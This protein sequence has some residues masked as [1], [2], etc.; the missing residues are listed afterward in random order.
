MGLMIV[1]FVVVAIIIFSKLSELN[2]KISSLQ[3][4]MTGLYK[5]IEKISPKTVAPPAEQLKAA[6]E[7]EIKIASPEI[8]AQKPPE[9]QVQPEK[10]KTDTS[11][12]IHEDTRKNWLKLERII[13]ERWLV[14][15]GALAFA[16]GFGVFMK[17]AFEQGWIN[18]V[19]R[20]TLGFL[21]GLIFIG[22]SEFL[23]KKNFQALAQGISALGL[24]ILYLTTFTAYHFYHMFG[25]WTA[26]IIFFATTVGGMYTAMHHNAFAT[27][28]LTTLGAFAT[29]LLLVDPASTVNYAPKLFSYL[30]IINAGVLYASSAKRWRILSLFSFLC[31]VFYFE[32]W[33][34]REYV[35]SDFLMAL[36]FAVIY[37]ITFSLISAVYSIIRKGRSKWEDIILV[38][39]N[40]VI[41]F[42]LLYDILD[43]AGRTALLPCIPLLMAAYH[44]ILAGIIRKINGRDIFL[45]FALVGTAVGLLTL[46]VPMLVKSYW[47][48]AVWGAEALIFL[49]IGS[50][51]DR[52]SLRIGGLAIFFLVVLRLFL[53]DSA[54]PY[55]RIYDSLLFFNR[56]FLALLISSLTFGLAGIS[57][58]K[59]KN[60]TPEEKEYSAPLWAVFTMALFWIANIEVFTYFSASGWTDGIE[61]I[62]TTMLWAVFSF[63]LF[64]IGAKEKIPAF[65]TAGLILITAASLKAVIDSFFTCRYTYG[66]PLLFNLKFLSV[67]TLLFTM[68]YAAALYGSERI[69][70][71]SLEKTAVPYL[72]GLF[73]I[74]LF[75]ELNVEYFYSCAAV[76]ELGEQKTITALSFLWILYGAGLLIAGIIKKSLPLRIGA[77]SLFGI[78]LLKVFFV[79]MQ[80]VGQTYKIL[81]LLGIGSILLICAYFYRRYR[82]RL[83]DKSELSDSK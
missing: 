51:L 16:T 76:W 41:F 81:L 26:F 9:P 33:Y 80:A 7:K 15:V 39:V 71:T 43:N 42:F 1:I 6:P 21:A 69:E 56:K 20:I 2:E 14:W 64:F 10:I 11:R 28:F 83:E 50:L 35:H 52:K 78:T 24:I 34:S 49:A 75:I 61:W 54:I 27:A 55:G 30:L 59:L 70:K 13:G 31:T 47:I 74:L 53:L 46:P 5:E 72:W 65:R 62:L 37:F 12:E 3:K 58:S 38:I 36:G 23:Y 82:K 40:P 4:R 17:Y 45:Y 8:P 60:I 68:A 19:A 29:P 18:E 22:L 73:I 66:C 48:T 77:L 25:A 32:R 63:F 57:T 67:A 44:F 79:D